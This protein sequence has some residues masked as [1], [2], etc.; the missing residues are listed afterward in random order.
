SARIRRRD[1][2]RHK[3]ERDGGALVLH[4]VCSRV[5]PLLE[6]EVP[7][8]VPGLTSLLGAGRQNLLRT[9]KSCKHVVWKGS[10]LAALHCGR[11]PEPPIIYGSPP[12]IVETN[13]GRR[14][15]GS[16]RLKQLVP[17]VVY[18]HMKMHKRILGHLSSV[19][20][21]T[22]DRTGRRIFTGSD[23]CLVKIWGTDDG[24]L[25]A[26][27]RGHAAEISDMA[28]SYEN[29]MIAAGSCD[30]TIRVWCLQTCAP[31]AVLEGHAASITS[32]Q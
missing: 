13:F 7:A 14:L 20:C 8:S 18:L 25:L 29:T 27:L 23:D 21:V 2:L 10:A 12:N 17:T 5:C 4:N 32:L 11:P 22:F 30:K 16:Y 3:P 9:S 1:S 28:V 6:T 31:L 15:N 19:Y 26:T 24:R